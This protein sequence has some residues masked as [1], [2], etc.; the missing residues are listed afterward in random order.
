M[1]PNNWEVMNVERA[2]NFFSKRFA[3]A[4]RLTGSDAGDKENK[5]HRMDGQPDT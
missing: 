4:I 3:S 2:M 1:A 5:I